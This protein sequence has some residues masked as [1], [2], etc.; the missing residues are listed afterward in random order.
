MMDL[1]AKGLELYAAWEDAVLETSDGHAMSEARRAFFA[2]LRGQRFTPAPAA[3]FA[4]P[5][6]NCRSQRLRQNERWGAIAESM[7]TEGGLADLP[8]SHFS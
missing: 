6:T 4:V 8:R 7:T 3:G 1:D 2:H 5:M